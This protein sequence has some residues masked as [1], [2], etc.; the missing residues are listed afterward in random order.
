MQH[1]EPLL[2][3]TLIKAMLWSESKEEEEGRTMELERDF[4]EEFLKKQ[5]IHKRP[6]TSKAA[7]VAHAASAGPIWLSSSGSFPAFS[8]EESSEWETTAQE[9]PPCPEMLSPFTKTY[10]LHTSILQTHN[11]WHIPVNTGDGTEEKQS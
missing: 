6:E 11:E 5:W 4:M 10:V 1:F 3:L 2:L 7:I 9:A 8:L